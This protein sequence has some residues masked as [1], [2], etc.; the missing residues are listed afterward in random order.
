M[1]SKKNS[2]FFKDFNNFIK[3]KLKSSSQYLHMRIDENHLVLL[4]D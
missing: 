4:F 2:I 3:F 1:V